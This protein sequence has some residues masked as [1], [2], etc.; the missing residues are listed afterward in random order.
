ML[1]RSGFSLRFSL[2]AC[3]A[4]VFRCS[5]FGGETGQYRVIRPERFALIW[6]ASFAA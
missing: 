4:V 3:S 5:S 2:A 6:V 1:V